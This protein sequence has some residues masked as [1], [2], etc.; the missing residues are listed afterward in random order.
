MLKVVILGSGN[1]FADG[2]QFQ[3]A[4]YLEFHEKD[5]ILLDCGPAILQA[6]QAAEVNLDDL[7]YL[8]ISHLHGDHIAGI[9][10]LLLHYKFVIKRLN[11]PLQIIGPPGLK[12]QLLDLLNGNY[13]NLLTAENLFITHEINLNEEKKIFENITV[14]SY[15]AY[16]IPNAFG[17]TIQM[18]SLKDIYSRD[19]KFDPNQIYNF[20][21]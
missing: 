14:R 21:D 4:H 3:S 10:F 6:I 7:Q 16:H 1:A 20:K 18:E 9:P 17:Y 11:N 19:N 15:E 5:K 2:N 12:N 13:P 8:I